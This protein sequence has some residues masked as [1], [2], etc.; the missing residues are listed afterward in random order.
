[1]YKSMTNRV[2]L[3]LVCIAL[4]AA[5]AAKPVTS[6]ARDPLACGGDFRERVKQA[7]LV[8]SGTIR[9]TIPEVMLAVDRVDV[10]SNRASIEV[11]RVFKGEVRGRMLDF[12][13]FSPPPD[14]NA[15]AGPPLA[16]FATGMR[17]LVFLREDV[18]GYVVTIPLCQVEVLL[19]PASALKLPDMSAVPEDIRYS[20]IARELETAAFSIEPPAPGVAGYAVHYFPYVIDLVGG[21]ARPFL[22]HFA[23]SPS[24]ELR[25]VAQRWLTLLFDK[26][27]R[28]E[29]P[30][31]H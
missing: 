7:D 18:T 24:R 13:W 26:K 25:D 5:E 19:A 16:N 4:L 11:D 6:Q 22:Q 2:F 9:S 30:T 3:Q 20:E 31:I 10:T 1:M 17:F 23:E 15:Y 28:C 14:V 8:V 21:C 29:A 27:M 12:V